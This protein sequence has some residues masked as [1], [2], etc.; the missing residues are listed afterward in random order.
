MIE[1]IIAICQTKEDQQMWIN[2]INK[3]ISFAKQSSLAP[4]NSSSVIKMPPFMT[5]KS[6]SANVPKPPPHAVSSIPYIHLTMYFAR[7]VRKKIITRKILK[8]LLYKEYINRY[9]TEHVPRRR[10]HRSEYIIYP[11]KASI[12]WISSSSSSSVTENR[13]INERQISSNKSNDDERM[14]MTDDDEMTNGS[15]RCSSFHYI[16]KPVFRTTLKVIGNNCDINYNA[17]LKCSPNL[18]CEDLSK[19]DD[20]VEVYYELSNRQNFQHESRQSEPLHASNESN[21]DLHSVG[22]KSF[23]VGCDSF[24][25][26]E[27]PSI[28]DDLSNSV[29]D[30]SNVSDF[31]VSQYPKKYYSS[32]CIGSPVIS[33]NEKLNKLNNTPFSNNDR[34]NCEKKKGVPASSLLQT[35]SSKENE[36]C[37]SDC[38]RFNNTCKLSVRS[39][40]SGLAD[41]TSSLINTSTRGQLNIESDSSSNFEGHC[42][43]TSPF[44]TTPHTSASEEKVY[45]TEYK[46]ETAAPDLEPATFKSGMYAHWWLKTK[47]PAHVLKTPVTTGFSSDT[48]KANISVYACFLIIECH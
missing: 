38:H 28:D 43:C 12:T 19:I 41:I 10:V 39:S 26:L 7:L 2:D 34:N 3:Q 46:V 11:E 6:H 25:V 9:N 5:G 47:I 44:E 33:S 24:P 37:L 8:K 20:N 22:F 4:S 29:S 40:D 45:I 1:E 16:S 17:E 35:L 27:P 21:Y 32:Y 23:S 48:G 14:S 30:K 15:K 36:R 13:C 42:V 18:V 31:N